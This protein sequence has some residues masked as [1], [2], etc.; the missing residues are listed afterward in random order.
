M[1]IGGYPHYEN[2]ASNYLAYFLGPDQPHDLGD[3]LVRT[4][5]EAIPISEPYYPSEDVT[6]FREYTTNEGKRIDLLIV[7]DQHVI[8]IEHKIYHT[9]GNHLAHYKKWIKQQYPNHVW[10]GVVLHAKPLDKDADLESFTALPHSRWWQIIQEEKFN[11]KVLKE[12]HNFQYSFLQE[13][14]KTMKNIENGTTMNQEAAEFLAR[15][16]EDIKNVNKIV[17]QF[18]TTAERQIQPIKEELDKCEHLK[19]NKQHNQNSL[20]AWE[21]LKIVVFYQVINFAGVE[22]KVRITPERCTL[23]FWN[24]LHYG[25]LVSTVAANGFELQAVDRKQYYS[26]TVNP[27]PEEIHG[28]V[29]KVLHENLA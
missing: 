13:L 16:T 1:E 9:L 17:R 8:A 15:H 25:K 5:W 20:A 18:L 4:L 23:E 14:M 10:Y 7:L 29:N 28:L 6:V 2:V 11:K 24:L 12:D 19:Y 22:C 27:N 26:I 3:L 21:G